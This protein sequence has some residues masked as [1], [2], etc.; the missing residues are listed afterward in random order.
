[1]G[2]VEEVRRVGR[3]ADRSGWVDV[4]ARL[5]FVAYGV[6]HLLVAW[7]A[8][9]L[10]VGRNAGHASPDG[11]LARLARQPFGHVLVWAVAVGLFLLVVWRALELVAGPRGATDD[12][13][14]LRGRLGSL[15][16]G[17]VYAAMGVLAVGIATRQKGAGSSSHESRTFTAR[18]MDWPAG[19]WIVGLI[20]LGIVVVGAALV[21]RGWTDAFLDQLDLAGR[22]G[23]AGTVDTWLGRVG[24]VAKGVAIG[25][26]GCL[27]G[28]AAL[29]HDPS[30]SGGLDRALR[31][32][33]R[34]PYGPVLL[35]AIATGIAC[36]GL[37]CFV[38][39]R[40]LSR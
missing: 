7:V 36:Y 13:A 33:L 11:A 10:V 26:V 12:A 18:V 40:H 23:T 22:T 19:P 15:G 4:T 16:A 34:Q 31:D 24:H 20:G 6:V 29:T 30:R 21:R 17:V 5:G 2:T 3:E 27:F 37:F 9:D 1:M 25:I 32:V 8:V 39:S 35:L 28:Y 38:R 14:R